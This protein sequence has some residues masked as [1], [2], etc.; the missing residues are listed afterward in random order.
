MDCDAVR[1]SI[2]N[3]YQ[4]YGSSDKN[5]FNK[6][7]SKFYTAGKQNPSVAHMILVDQLRKEGLNQSHTNKQLAKTFKDNSKIDTELLIPFVDK[8]PVI[9]RQLNRDAAELEMCL[10]ILKVLK[11]NETQMTD[12]LSK[13][14]KPLKEN[15]DETYKSLYPKTYKIRK[16]IIENTNFSMDRVVSKRSFYEKIKLA[17][18]EDGWKSVYP[19][20]YE[21]RCR[22]LG[23]DRIGKSG[24]VSWLKKKV[25]NMFF[26]KKHDMIKYFLRMG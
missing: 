14:V 23:M 16:K 19:N 25:W 20:S 10:G 12:L 9:K 21:T 3:A 1:T 15:F 26:V 17:E 22:L 7:M 4:A 6:S 11:A 13:E 8:K 2:I 18:P 24:T 5:S